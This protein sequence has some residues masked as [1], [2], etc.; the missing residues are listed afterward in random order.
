MVGDIN[1]VNNFLDFKKWQQQTQWNGLPF[2]GK[3]GFIL[4]CV[5]AI[6]LGLVVGNA[7][8]PFLIWK[9]QL[10]DQGISPGPFDFVFSQTLGIFMT[11]SMVML[12]WG[13]GARVFKKSFQK[14]VLRPAY[15]SGVMWG[16]GF[17][18]QI[19]S[20]S[21]LAFIVAYPLT[22]I[23]PVMCSTLWSVLYFREIEGRTNHQY[24]SAALFLMICGIVLITLS[25]GFVN[26]FTIV[27]AF[28]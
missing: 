6:C 13:T 27:A 5:M 23:G 15:W 1:V 8:T 25:R 12:C 22:A 2:S 16:L 20:T 11:S 10:Q 9:K 21:E 7:L 3:S 4:G 24:L 14:P 19:V 18:G 26:Y 28:R 17:V